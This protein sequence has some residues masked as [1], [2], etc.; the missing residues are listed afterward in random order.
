[1]YCMA[2]AMCVLQPASSLL[3]FA[4]FAAWRSFCAIV[5]RAPVEDVDMRSACAIIWAQV[6]AEVAAAGVA[7]LDIEFCA[8]TG[9][10]KQSAMAQAAMEILGITMFS[11]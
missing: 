5:M 1:M 9:S 2:F 8:K 7:L 3:A 10:E 4:T 11:Q 6:M